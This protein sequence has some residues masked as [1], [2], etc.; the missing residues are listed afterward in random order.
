MG[1]IKG[2]SKVTVHSL[3]DV[4]VWNMI[5]SK[6]ETVDL[7]CDRV[8]KQTMGQVRMKVSKRTAMYDLNQRSFRLTKRMNV[9]A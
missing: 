8:T 5:T 1:Y 4:D 2:N 3:A 7:W 9:L 6:G